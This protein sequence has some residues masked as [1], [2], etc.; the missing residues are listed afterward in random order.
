M[1]E[2]MLTALGF[3]FIIALSI[4]LIDQ[5]RG[6][7]VKLATDVIEVHRRWRFSLLDI[8]QRRIELEELDQ[9]T[10]DPSR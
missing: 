9:R 6:Y 7:L 3:V 5:L 2:F 8:E 1:F 10:N 4:F